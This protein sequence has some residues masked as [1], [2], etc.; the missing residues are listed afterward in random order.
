MSVR[1]EK[2]YQKDESLHDKFKLKVI[3][4]EEEIAIHKDKIYKELEKKNHKKLTSHLHLYQKYRIRKTS[5]YANQDRL[6]I[7]NNEETDD[8]INPSNELITKTVPYY[9]H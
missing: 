5:G 9:C 6:N 4:S 7:R 8:F 2:D 1:P 3:K